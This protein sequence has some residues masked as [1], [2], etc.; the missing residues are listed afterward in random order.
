MGFTTAGNLRKLHEKCLCTFLMKRQRLHQIFQEGNLV[1]APLKPTAF[2]LE[3][4]FWNVS[5]YRQARNKDR[6]KLPVYTKALAMNSTTIK[7]SAPSLSEHLSSTNWCP[8]PHPQNKQ[9][10]KWTKVNTP[11]GRVWRGPLAAGT[12]I[13][14]GIGGSVGRGKTNGNPSHLL[15]LE[16]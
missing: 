4:T 9:T 8:P 3:S 13:F 12:E 2:G 11:R 16:S 5:T 10:W 14:G 7:R 1:T 15:M 6:C